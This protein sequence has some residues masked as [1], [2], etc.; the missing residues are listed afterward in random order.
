M[1]KSLVEKVFNMK[2]QMKNQQG[3]GSYSKKC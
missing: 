1:L 3:A 2:D